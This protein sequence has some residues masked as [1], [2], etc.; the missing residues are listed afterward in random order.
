MFLRCGSDI[1]LAI[2]ITTAVIMGNEPT[3]TSCVLQ[4]LELIRRWVD[5]LEGG[6]RT[7]AFEL[8]N[9]VMAGE[10]TNDEAFLLLD[11]TV[12]KTL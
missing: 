12:S 11:N 6:N 5:E 10:L 3:K 8:M 1:V 7:Y 4:G 2:S 9:L